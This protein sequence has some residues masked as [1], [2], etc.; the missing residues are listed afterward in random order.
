M[1]LRRRI[2]RNWWRGWFR[3]SSV[4][5][6][7]TNPRLY[8]LL[9]LLLTGV[10]PTVAQRTLDPGSVQANVY[11]NDSLGITWE[12]PAEWIVQKQEG[13]SPTDRLTVL[14]QL[15]AGDDS[16]V[17]AAEDYRDSPGFSSGYS[18]ALKAALEKKDWK[19]YGSRGFR[20]I[21]GGVGAL[22]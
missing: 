8:W 2:I 17:L 14:L 7:P 22:E 5:D 21:G 3:L 20:T 19:S 15:S 12:F 18:D 1:A 6:F 16:I 9:F 10:P 4:R 11:S 13:K